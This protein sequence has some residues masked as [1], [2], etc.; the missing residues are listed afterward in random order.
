[1]VG[2]AIA[3]VQLIS[4]PQTQRFARQS[5]RSDGDIKRNVPGI[6]NSG[7]YNGISII[8]ADLGEKYEHGMITME[9]RE[10]MAGAL[11]LLCE[12]M[13]QHFLLG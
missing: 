4:S 6:S 11:Y 2:A 3:C 10:E 13:L 12:E 9:F 7:P 1:M 5:E 8:F